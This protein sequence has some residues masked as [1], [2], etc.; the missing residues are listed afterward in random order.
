MTTAKPAAKKPAA[1]KN[2]SPVITSEKSA[3]PASAKATSVKADPVKEASAKP[4]VKAAAPAKKAPAGKKS[5]QTKAVVKKAPV[6]KASEASAIAADFFSVPKFELP[7]FDLPRFE[8]PENPL[9]EMMRD[10][11]EQSVTNARETYDKTKASLDEQ[12]AAVEKSV[13]TAV[14]SATALNRKTLDA[15]Q[16]NITAGFDFV[17]DI[18]M[19]KTLGDVIEMQTSFARKQFD[20]VAE[21]NKDFQ[22]ILAKSVEDVSTPV[23]KAMESFKS[24]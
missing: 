14:E 16:A 19:A 5:A 7:G 9:P 21:Q 18:M 4:A 10:M 6:A 8:L 20:A 17:R 12:Q 24:V 1:A 22:D 15:A 11:A 23:K 2:S 13:E 3:A